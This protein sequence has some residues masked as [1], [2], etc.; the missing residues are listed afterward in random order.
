MGFDLERLGDD[1][2]VIRAIP[3]VFHGMIG[4]AELPEVMLQLVDERGKRGAD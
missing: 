4:E 1:S 3:I 2:Y